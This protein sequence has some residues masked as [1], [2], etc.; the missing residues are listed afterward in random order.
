MIFHPFSF[1]FNYFSLS[2]R[3]LL[4]ALGVYGQQ[5]TQ[6]KTPLE[7]LEAKQREWLLIKQ[8]ITKLKGIEHHSLPRSY[9]QRRT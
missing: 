9:A 8:R 1:E 7:K 6:I 2:D 5:T 4:Q 3:S